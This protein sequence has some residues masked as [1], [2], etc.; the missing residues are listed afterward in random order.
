MIHSD[1]RAV[2]SGAPSISRHLENEFLAEAPELTWFRTPDV[3]LA[4][5]QQSVREFDRYE[6]AV[7][8][9]RNSLPVGVA[10]VV[11]EFDDHVG[12]CLSVQWRFVRPAFRGCAGRELHRAVLRLA[13]QL[14]YPV[15]A[16]TRRIGLGKYELKYLRIRS[17]NEQKHSKDLPQ[18]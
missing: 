15:V 2:A 9:E 13:A 10:I 11:E 3:A 18:D 14:D 1:F 4:N 5:I 16:Y 6:I 7:W 12:Q 17:S 8:S